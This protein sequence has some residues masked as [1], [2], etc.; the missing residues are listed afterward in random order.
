MRMA[1]LD[2]ASIVC[3][4]LSFAGSPVFYRLSRKWV[5]WFAFV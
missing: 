5:R 2:E 3:S 1:I 4:T